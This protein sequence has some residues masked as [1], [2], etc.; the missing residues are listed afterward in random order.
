MFQSLEYARIV[1]I[2]PMRVLCGQYI[3]DK[4]VV[5]N[6]GEIKRLLQL[7]P[8]VIYPRGFARRRGYTYRRGLTMTK[9]V[10]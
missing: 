1:G 6:R 3:N 2:A 10:M 8:M 9:G 7:V 5:F 4:Y